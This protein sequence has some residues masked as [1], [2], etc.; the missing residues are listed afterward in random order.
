MNEGV[1]ILIERMKTHPEEFIAEA[2]Y[3]VSKWGNLIA[4]YQAYLSDEDR[5]A[6]DTSYKTAVNQAMQERFTA[7]IMEELLDPKSETN[8]YLS[9][10]A[11]GT[12]LGGA[13]Q[14]LTLTVPNGGTQLA[15]TNSTGHTSI[16]A[17]T[18][19][20]GKQTLDEATL[21][22]MKAHVDWMKREAQLRQKEKKSKTLFGK[23]FNYT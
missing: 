15:W 1:Q 18:L 11:S 14:G 16:N 7:K 17:N 2:Q 8:P 6:L 21:E 13:T 19:T 12:V 4:Q 20:L 9:N 23:L 3:G 5:N 10:V 22:H